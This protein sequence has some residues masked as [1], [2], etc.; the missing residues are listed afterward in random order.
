MSKMKTIALAFWVSSS[1]LAQDVYLNVGGSVQ[2]GSTNVYC[3]AYQEPEESKWQCGCFASGGKNLGMVW[4]IWAANQRQAEAN[5]LR[6]CGFE[7][8][9]KGY[10]T[11]TSCS[12]QMF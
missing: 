8:G 11:S 10:T 9:S 1:A 7:Y 6:Q 5:A 4:G 3:G 2:V 12:K